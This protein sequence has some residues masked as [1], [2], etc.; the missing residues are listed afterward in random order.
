MKQST[1]SAP[2]QRLLNDRQGAAY[3]GVSR[4]QFRA[5]VAAGN[6]PRVSVPGEDGRP[7]RRLLVDR[8]DLDGLIEAWK[9]R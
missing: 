2:A 5:L 8:G 7:L 6:V 9:R 4:S 1:P 3:L